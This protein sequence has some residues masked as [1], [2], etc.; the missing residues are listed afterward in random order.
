[1][2]REVRHIGPQGA[3]KSIAIIGGGVMGAFTAAHLLERGAHVTL[4]DP[5]PLGQGPGASVD[6]GRSFRVHYGTDQGLISMAVRSRALWS[7]WSERLGRPLLHPTGKLLVGESG[8]EGRDA[9]DSWLTLRKMGLRA[10]RMGR[11]PIEEEW[12]GF[13]A[14]IGTVDRLGGVLDPEVILGS[15]AGWLSQH[16]LVQKGEVLELEGQRVRC[17]QGWQAFDQVVLTSGA[18]SRRWLSLPMEVTRQELVYFDARS[19]GETL[20][21]LP[22]FS[23]PES[24]FYAIPTVKDGRIKIA[25]HH[26]GPQGHPD[27]DLRRVSPEFEAA[28]RAFLTRHLPGLADAEVVRRYVCFYSGTADRDFILDR[29]PKGWVIGAGFSGHGFKF[30]PLIGRLLAQLALGEAPEVDLTRFSLHREALHGA[31]I[32]LAV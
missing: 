12:P 2:K 6:T 9:L 32:R 4:Y 16:N 27:G 20:N 18:W 3:G 14:D 8:S 21:R 7:Q 5:N 19:L 30:S 25:N 1:M 31:R 24:G 28:A 23:H 26:P 22:V 17:S 29:T 13:S 15:L 11:G 10:D